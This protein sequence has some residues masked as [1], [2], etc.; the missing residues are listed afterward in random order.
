[1]QAVARFM[2][3]AQPW[4]GNRHALA[5]QSEAEYNRRFCATVNG[6]TKTRHGYTHSNGRSFVKVDCETS[7]TVYEGGL[8]KRSSLGQPA[9]GAVFQCVDRQAAG[10]GDL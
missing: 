8:D 2:T 4:P 6:E 9:A 10:G 7:T 3:V 5:L 1:M